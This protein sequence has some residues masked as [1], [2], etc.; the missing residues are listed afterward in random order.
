MKLLI[1]PFFALAIGAAFAQQS[2]VQPAFTPDIFMPGQ[3]SVRVSLYVDAD[4]F[5]DQLRSCLARELR[6]I[7]GVTVTSDHPGVQVE[8]IAMT[9]AENNSTALGF[10]SS[11]LMVQTGLPFQHG[12]QISHDLASLCTA[13]ASSIDQK[14]IEPL[15]EGWQARQ[16]H[17]THPLR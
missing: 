1:V 4:I 6:A 11:V 16:D 8:I 12:L 5:T 13:I 15:R 10:T 14:S 3:F 7:P 9:M 2:P 17:A